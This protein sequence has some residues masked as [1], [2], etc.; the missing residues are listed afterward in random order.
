MDS[1]GEGSA[2]T[3]RAPTFALPLG[4]WLL[5]RP[6]TAAGILVLAG[7]SVPFLSRDDSEWEYVYVRAA[8]E[9]RAG[10]DIY[11]PDIGNSY[12]P[13][14]A[15]TAL[16]FTALP[17]RAGRWLW[18]AVNL[19]C[20]VFMLRGAWRLAGGEPVQR[21]APP[22][23][24]LAAIL[25]ALCGVFYLQNCLAHQQTD[26]V[27]GALLIAGA[28]ALARG[29][30][31]WAATCF[32]LAA[33]VKCTPLLWAPYLVWRRR[34]L[35]AAWLLAV[36]LG[37]NLLP[38]LV[39]H[40]ESGR[41]WLSEYYHRY[42]RPL[43]AAEHS[44]GTWHSDIVYNQSLAGAAQRW[45]TT[46]C[47]WAATDCVVGDRSG[48]VGPQGLKVVVYG[49]EALLVLP[50]L[51]VCR[52]PFQ[53][54]QPESPAGRRNAPEYCAVLLLMLLLSPMSSKAHFGVLI[55]PG[56]CLARAALVDNRRLLLPV[57]AAAVL[58]AVASNKDLLGERLYTLSLWLGCVTWETL[59][60]LAGCLVLVARGDSRPSPGML[61]R[62]S[63]ALL[64]PAA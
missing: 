45:L 60:L 34:P 25:G 28:L 14:A 53:R 17:P 13:F 12:P 26:V 9:L 39:A 27:L 38:D 11:R 31:L 46:T 55:L 16:P 33:A 37:A 52:R 44:P 4:R 21:G 22:R 18:L 64:R 2:V 10:N 5:D 59:V 36:A 24:H 62:T 56:F 19:G 57:L 35:A 58:L 43:A 51:A 48:H 23:V 47:E 3:A 61:P 41:L 50:T 63:A 20:L 6:Y 32:G 8:H 30:S 7:L 42:L 49:A 54:N 40:P 29:R 15:L 1:P